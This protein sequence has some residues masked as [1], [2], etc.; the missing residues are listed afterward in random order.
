MI[1][2]DQPTELFPANVLVAV[3]SRQDGTMLDR[4]AGIHH[5]TARNNRI[6]FCRQNGIAYQ[7]VVYQEIVYTDGH[8]YDHIEEV[9]LQ[10]AT[11]V[12]AGV[13]ADALITQA[14]G[15]TLM[16][17]VA[18]CIATVVYDPIRRVLALLH[19]GRHSTLSSLIAQVMTKFREAG[20]IPSDCIVWMGPH[21][22]ASD[23]VMQWFNHAEE[24]EW[25]E[26][27]QRQDD[28]YHLDLAGFNQARF[29]TQ[30]I[31]SQHIHRSSLNTVTHPEYFSHSAGDVSGRFVVIAGL[32]PSA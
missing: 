14:P 8:S 6:D 25:K 10:D 15:V 26:F 23:Y 11:A 16:L 29:E 5:E 17:P 9:G 21:A 24:P 20:S 32:S 12:R 30:G 27:C 19:L 7:D 2:A 28:G 13:Q 22:Q 18:D 31:L 3:S 4:R 1:R